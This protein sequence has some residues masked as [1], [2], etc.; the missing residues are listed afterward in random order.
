MLGGSS[1]VKSM[2]HARPTHR[3]RRRLGRRLRVT[4]WLAVV[5]LLLL[6]VGAGVQ[7]FRPIQPPVL[8]W[9]VPAAL[10]FAGTPPK[11]PMPT[12]GEAIVSVQGIGTLGSMNPDR[13]VPVASITKVMTA[14]L[15]LHDHPL[16]PGQAGPAIAVTA[17]D[18]AAYKADAAGGQSTLAVTAGET[19]T[20]LQALEGLLI[21]SA[22]NVANILARWDSG[23]VAAF[24]SKMNAQAQAFGLAGT[25]FADP[26]GL[27]PASVSTPSDLLRL[28]QAAM[29]IPTF[30][31]IVAMPQVSLPGVGVVYN[32]DYDVGHDGIVG[33]KT[34]SDGAAGG[35]FLFESRKQVGR[36]SVTIVGDVL[37]QRGTSPI[38]TALAAAEKLVTA[39]AST[40]G[41]ATI[42]AA[43]Q[44]LGR[45]T[46]PWGPS[47][48]VVA[49]APASFFGW[50]GLTVSTRLDARPLRSSPARGAQLGTLQLSAGGQV[51]T[52]PLRVDAAL[53]GPGPRWRLTRL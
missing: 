36:R 1:S 5:L 47:V 24:V 4:G 8:S 11:L 21:P 46:A 2:R 10:R 48:P 43:G 7:W 9:S 45:V 37:G 44:Q 3:F 34:G 29:A 53:P 32:F 23:T 22:N 25:H 14:Y 42:V 28:A 52:V 27:D 38:T 31:A 50:P 40:L 41:T 6:A 39:A 18:A 33:I 49:S 35:C 26:S 30:A 15:V 17:A 51:A 20:E 12:V 19:L 13:S 16:G